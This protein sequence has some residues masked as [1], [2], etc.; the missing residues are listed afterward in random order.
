MLF[1]SPHSPRG[2]SSTHGF[3]S[4]SEVRVRWE[5]ASEKR[6]PHTRS[7]TVTSPGNSRNVAR[8]V[9]TDSASNPSVGQSKTSASGLV[10][11]AAAM[12]KRRV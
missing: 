4:P 9:S 8:N 5:L 10:S 12:A 1:A 3:N 7:Y 2:T 6:A 11:S